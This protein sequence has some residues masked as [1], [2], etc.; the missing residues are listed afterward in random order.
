MIPLI[1]LLV[2]TAI[3]YVNPEA[4]NIVH[5]WGVVVFQQTGAVFCGGPWYDQTPDPF[6]ICAE[7]PVVWLYGQPFTGTFTVTVPEGGAVT[8]VHPQPSLLS[9]TQAAWYLS[10]MIDQSLEES[11]PVQER[12]MYNGPYEWAL[13]YWREVPSLTFVVNETG[14]LENFLYYECT[15]NSDFTGSFLQWGADG[16]PSFRDNAEGEALY[17]APGGIFPVTLTDERF[18]PFDLP[19]GGEVDP[20]LA[21]E[22]FCRW[23]GSRL[24]S[25]EITALWETWEPVLT[26]EGSYW[27][28]FPIPGE[29]LGRISTISLQTG[30]RG[31][32]EYE[33]LFLGAVRL[34]GQ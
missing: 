15:V 22:T 26:E 14:Q 13:E 24:K 12:Y 23:A 8:F 9:E 34:T 1:P 19:M 29:Y 16:N 6:D 20:D 2:D 18:I 4:M 21:S 28:V 17:F 11:L 30:N 33:R 5:E 7:A 32:V 3:A 31:D 27:I 10:T 25:E